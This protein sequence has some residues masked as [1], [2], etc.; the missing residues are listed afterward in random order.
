MC[1]WGI[2][3]PRGDQGRSA[4]LETLWRVEATDQLPFAAEVARLS[5]QGYTVYAL[6]DGEPVEPFPV[7]C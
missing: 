4:G 3:W 7:R 5:A 1:S 6:Q 2:G